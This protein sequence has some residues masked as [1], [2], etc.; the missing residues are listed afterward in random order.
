[1][2]DRAESM[3]VASQYPTIV[4]KLKN[5]GLEWSETLPLSPKASAISK[6]R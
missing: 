2:R 3:N 4:N 5:L 1:M 6:Q